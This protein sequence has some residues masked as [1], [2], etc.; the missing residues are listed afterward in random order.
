MAA[1]PDPTDDLSADDRAVYDHMAGTRSHADGRDQLG[2]VYVR[3]FNNP[4]VARAVGALGEHLR[5][6]GL[7]PDVARELAVLRYASRLH[8]GYEWS[9]HQR[10]ARLAGIGEATVDAVTRGEVPGSLPDELQAVLVAVDAVVSLR[11]IPTD[12]QDRLVDAFGTAGV[13]ELVAVCGLYGVMG[14][15]VTAFEIPT[16]AGL[17]PAPF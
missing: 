16:E 1:L 10:P 4:G 8:L 6:A 14:C 13:V 15:M 5:Y 7:L 9:H 17:P 11:S 3:M 2:Q 12:V